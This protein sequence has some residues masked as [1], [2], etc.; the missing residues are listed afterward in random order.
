[1]TGFPPS[2]S[3]QTDP[4]FALEQLGA[5][6]SQWETADLAPLQQ[7]VVLE[8]MR[9]ARGGG[10]AIRDPLMR[11]YAVFVERASEE[12][13][14]QALHTVGRIGESVARASRTP[15]GAAGSVPFLADPAPVIVATAVLQLAC[16]EGTED[17]PLSGARSVFAMALTA[18]D[19][20][21][22]AAALGA[23]LSLGDAAV[24]ELLGACWEHLDPGAYAMFARMACGSAATPVVVDF[25]LRWAEAAV[26]GGSET[27]LGDIAA[28]LLALAHR[29]SAEVPGLGEAGVTEIDHGLPVWT[30]PEDQVI[31]VVRRWTRDEYGR[32]I[33]PRLVGVARRES[34]PRILP[35]VLRAW[36]LADVPHLEAVAAAV[37]RAGGAKPALALF[38]RPVPVETPP[39]WDQPNVILE[40]GVLSPNG[41]TMCQVSLV[42]LAGD[43]GRAV[44]WTQHHF[45]QPECVA[46]AAGPSGGDVGLRAA[47]AA[48]FARNG[49]AERPLLASLPHWVRVPEGGPLDTGAAAALIG[50]AH[51]AWLRAN[52]FQGE[53]PDAERETLRRLA[54]DPIADLERQEAEALAASTAAV[55]VPASPPEPA[56]YQRWMDVAASPAHVERVRGFYQSAWT[57][58]IRR[59]NAAHSARQH[60]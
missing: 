10:D 9:W 43:G 40:W 33:A 27:G 56:A 19:A 31:K 11:L 23:L 8:S 32:L 52:G 24:A 7:L 37:G 17:D 4:F 44:V 59:W 3:D 42:P 2:G 51:T 21:R 15:D 54:E 46:W 25:F 29:A 45:L 39:D 49:S 50:T 58:A 28:A 5:D 60:S 30:R 38:D 26:S 12:Q 18:D 57:E 35:R 34:H 53:H 1:M 16:L 41:P 48:V 20:G 14:M 47:L 6:P 55:P 22:R 36:G 13:R